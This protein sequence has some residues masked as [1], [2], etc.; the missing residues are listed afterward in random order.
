MVWDGVVWGGVLQTS[1]RLLGQQIKRQIARSHTLPRERHCLFVPQHRLV[2]LFR[3]E[4]AVPERLSVLVACA[5][6]RREREWELE[7]ELESERARHRERERD[8]AC[9]MDKWGS[10]C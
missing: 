5:A 10:W 4:V 9:E 1:E 3:D 8:R 6:T 2:G 7:W